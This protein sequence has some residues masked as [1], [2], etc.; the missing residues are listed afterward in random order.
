M[1]P[2]IPPVLI[3]CAAMTSNCAKP[4]QRLAAA[5][6]VEMPAEARRPCELHRLPAKPTQADLEVGYAARG[7]QIVACDA[8]R[9][10]AVDTHDAEH[11]LEE[12][13]LKARR[14]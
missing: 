13:A 6:Q 10:L 4:P 1:R 8:A 9:R 14:R 5:P 12:E 7:A 11:G 3:V 2:L